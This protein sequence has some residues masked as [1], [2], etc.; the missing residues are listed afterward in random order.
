TLALPPRPGAQKEDVALVLDF[1]AQDHLVSI[2]NGSG[3]EL[4]RIAWRGAAPASA[5]VQG[6]DVSIGFTGQAIADAAAWAHGGST[7]GVVVELPGRLPAYWAARLEKLTAGSAEWRHAQRQRMVALAAVGD[8]PALFAAYEALRKQGG[9]ERGDLVLAG[10]G[11]VTGTRDEQVAAA[12]A[13]HR[14]ASG[15]LASYLEAGRAYTARPSPEAMKPRATAGLVGAM[16]ALREVSAYAAAGSI[17]K[18]TDRLIAMGSRAFELR[19]L[20]A[21]LIGLRYDHPADTARAWESVAQALATA[22]RYDAAAERIA[23]LVADLDL[24]AAPPSLGSFQYMFQ[25]SRRGSA[26]WQLVV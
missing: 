25:S 23:A 10:G 26:G 24:R 18:A 11:I 22:G 3:A 4:V 2:A 12:L 6:E 9:V 14:A 1:D 21:G 17:G 13:P 7:P 15:E 5:R 8:R 16:W 20:G 19:L